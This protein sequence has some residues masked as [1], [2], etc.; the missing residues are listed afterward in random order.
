MKFVKPTVNAYCANSLVGGLRLAEF[1][2]RLCYKSEGKQD[3]TSYKKF[4]LA[5]IEQGHT[6][7]LEH[8]PIYITCSGEMNDVIYDIAY[9]PYSK[10][11][12]VYGDTIDEETIY[13]YS[14][15]RVVYNV[16]RELAIT[17]INSNSEYGNEVWETYNAEW[18]VPDVKDPFLRITAYMITHRSIVDELVR[19]RVQSSSVESTRFC[20]YNKHNTGDSNV[21]YALPHWITNESFDT[22]KQLFAAE[23]KG[24]DL[25]DDPIERLRIIASVAFVMYQAETNLDY[26]RCYHYMYACAQDEIFYKEAGNELQLKPEDAREYLFLGVKSEIFYSGFEVNW[27]N[28][29]GKRFYGIVGKPHPNMKNLM[30]MA[31]KHIKCITNE[32]V[33]NEQA[34]SN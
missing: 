29:I 24:K 8:C 33:V 28:I 10:R 13:I 31:M 34:R 30:Q 1:G 5:R 32:D 23:I 21:N 22:C 17:L 4:L 11:N 16:N 9:S 26:K 25:P 14:N 20:N 7:I 3:V 2:G 19:E 15:L 27:E 6:S 12:I 18:F